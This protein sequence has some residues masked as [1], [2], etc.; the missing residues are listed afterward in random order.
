MNSLFVVPQSIFYIWR[1]L[2]VP[3]CSHIFHLVFKGIL[4]DLRNIGITDNN[5]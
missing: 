3:F 4:S 5:S 2:S 1:N